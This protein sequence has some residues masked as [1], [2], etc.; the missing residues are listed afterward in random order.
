VAQCYA[1]TIAEG[2][3]HATY[4]HGFAHHYWHPERLLEPLTVSTPSKI[5]LDSMSDLMGHWVHDTQIDAVL[6]ICK[7]ADWHTFQLL[8]KHPRRLLHFDYPPNVW[9]GVSMVPDV[10][11][12][13]ELTDIQQERWM[14][15]AFEVLG[16]LKDRGPNV[17]F[18]SFEPLSWPVA[19]LVDPVTLSWS[20][21]GA[22]SRGSHYYAPEKRA[23]LGLLTVLKD[24]DHPVPVFMKGNLRPF[25]QGFDWLEEFPDAPAPANPSAQ[26][27][28]FGEG[29]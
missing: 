11:N 12:G 16:E 20:I 13:G 29:Q 26:L 7:R 27:S 21:I 4:P 9:I 10:I 6:D 2:V 17:T 24:R 25:A 28:M 23:V 22:A 14:H 18:M 1:E 8:T 15:S 5:F 19:H 3:A